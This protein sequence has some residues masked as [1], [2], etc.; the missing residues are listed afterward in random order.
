MEIKTI[1]YIVLGVLYY[2]YKFSKKNKKTTK[3]TQPINTEVKEIESRQEDHQE[4]KSFDE[5]LEDFISPKKEPE[6]EAEL[7]TIED[8]KQK[9]Q[10]LESQIVE[11]G[12]PQDEFRRFKEFDEE[13]SETEDYSD[14]LTD[15][16]AA[17][18]AFVA[19]EIFNRKY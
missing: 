16:D 10:P 14:L 5:L 6:Q 11:G 18:R 13:E 1:I 3:S 2:V 7:R 19:S 4:S 8:Y 15:Q 17:K 12:V 9:L